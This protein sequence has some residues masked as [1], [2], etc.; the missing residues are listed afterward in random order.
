MMLWRMMWWRSRAMQVMENVA[1]K[2]QNIGRN[3][4]REHISHVP[5]TSEIRLLQGQSTKNSNF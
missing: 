4:V 2:L 5:A 3:P 1:R